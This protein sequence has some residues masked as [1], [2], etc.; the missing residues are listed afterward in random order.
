MGPLCLR[1]SSFSPR[2]QTVKPIVIPP[3]EPKSLPSL[4]P[5]SR[6]LGKRSFFSRHQYP[7]GFSRMVPPDKAVSAA[8]TLFF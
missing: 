8:H 5:Q 4:Q 3:P 2:S 6:I 7:I 1:L